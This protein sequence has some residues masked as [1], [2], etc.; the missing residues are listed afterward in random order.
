[1]ALIRC[2][3][4]DAL[5][6]D[7]AAACP[8]CGYP[9]RAERS[10]ASTPPTTPKKRDPLFSA[11]MIAGGFVLVAALLVSASSSSSSA[12]SDPGSPAED[13]YFFKGDH[14]TVPAG[15]PVCLTRSAFDRVVELS[16]DRLAVQRFLDDAA[17]G[18]SV[19]RTALD[20][21][22][23]ERATDGTRAGKAIVRVRRSGAVT[24]LWTLESFLK[25]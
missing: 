3:D 6:S 9:F 8:S 18:C 13:G 4:C 19:M 21:T 17:N 12:S 22:V 15:Y 11:A 16:G 5:A 20:V 24:S 7:A 14:G 10:G 25:P 2:A 1:M 23:E